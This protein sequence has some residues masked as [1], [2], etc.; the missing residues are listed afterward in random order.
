MRFQSAGEFVFVCGV[1]VKL[2]ILICTLYSEYLMDQR[3]HCETEV[4]VENACLSRAVLAHLQVAP[5][6]W[7]QFYW[8]C[9]MERFSYL[10]RTVVLDGCH[11]GNS[12]EK[13]L[14]G[15]RSSYEGKRVMVLFG[16]GHEKCLIDMVDRLFAHAD[17][18][19]MVQS[20]HFRA[21]TEVDLLKQVPEGRVH[22]LDDVHAA[23][24]ENSVR[25]S[26]GE[27]LQHA[28]ETSDPDK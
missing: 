11:N 9:R 20:K 14:K 7:E 18:V 4:H 13:F 16:A 5:I 2:F 28:V 12:M 6:G 15:L 25:H 17:Q 26:L 3:V 10:G 1:D 8:P 22:L 24:D 19:T 27:R 21:H 23:Q